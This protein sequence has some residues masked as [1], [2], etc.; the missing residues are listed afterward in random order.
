MVFKNHIHLLQAVFNV[1][2]V[3]IFSPGFWK[4]F[5]II[6]LHFCLSNFFPLLQLLLSHMRFRCS[7]VSCPV[8]FGFLINNFVQCFLMINS[9]GLYASLLTELF[10]YCPSPATKQKQITVNPVSVLR[11]IF[12]FLSP[13]QDLNCLIRNSKYYFFF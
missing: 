5:T 7:Q 10:S 2:L 13:L 3:S 11:V 9:S 4:G 1:T 12:L 8:S 6:I